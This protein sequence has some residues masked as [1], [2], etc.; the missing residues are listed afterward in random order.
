MHAVLAPRDGSSQA[1]ELLNGREMGEGRWELSM[2][3]SPIYGR[4]Q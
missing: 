4:L 2:T 1:I 3:A